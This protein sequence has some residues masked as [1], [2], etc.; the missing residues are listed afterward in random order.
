MIL[1][2]SIVAR[3][4]DSGRSKSFQTQNPS[5]SAT[6]AVLGHDD[7]VLAELWAVLMVI[8]IMIWYTHP[9]GCWVLNAPD[10]YSYCCVPPLF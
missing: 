2:I 10:L 3:E 7:T 1:G 4:L 8:C 6:A 5:A 9:A